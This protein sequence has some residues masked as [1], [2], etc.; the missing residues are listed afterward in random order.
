M[1]EQDILAHARRCAPGV[2][3]FRGEN[4]G[5]SRYSRVNFPAAPEDYFRMAPEDW[6]RAETQGDIVALVQPSRRPC[7][8][9]SDVTAGC[10]FKATCRGW[11]APAST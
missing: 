6:L 10:R 1:K 9:W 5:G 11:Y 8:I 3:R 2:V 7:R 4:T